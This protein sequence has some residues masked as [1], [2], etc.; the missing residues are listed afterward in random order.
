MKEYMFED[1]EE[2][3][4]IGEFE[5]EYVYDIEMDDETHTFIANDILV[6]NSSYVNLGPI[7]ETINELKGADDRKIC[8]F[9][10]GFAEGYMNDY[11]FNVLDDYFT[12]RHVKNRHFFELETVAKTGIWIGIKKRYAQALLWKDGRFYDEPKMKVKGLEVIKGSYPPFS[13]EILKDLTMTLL[14]DDIHHPD[15]IHRF[16]AKVMGWKDQFMHQDPD[17]IT[18][19]ISVSNYWKGIE[20][21]DD[22]KGLKAVKGA[23]F[24]VKAL[25]LYNWMINTRKYPEDNIYG[26]KVRCYPIKKTSAKSEDVYF[27]FPTGGFPSW[28]PP[29]DYNALY[30]KTVLEPINR[31]ITKIGLPELT[32]DGAIQIDLF[33]MF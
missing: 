25:G 11:F 31:I 16:N 30:T 24:N 17:Y 32:L 33:S 21:D 23:S 20:S 6:H 27:A 18:E 9:C 2:C 28:A 26:G 1:I 12:P 19:A 13:R 14:T 22:P 8:E 10:V 4:C 29:I 7:V 3:I 5:D 15:F